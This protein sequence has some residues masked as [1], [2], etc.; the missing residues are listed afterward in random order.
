MLSGIALVIAAFTPRRGLGV[1]AIITVLVVL[2]G[3]GGA[4]QG[5]A[6]ELNSHPAAGWFGLISPF[7]VVQGVQTWLLHQP[8]P[9][10]ADPPGTVG[11]LVFCA[12]T[13]LL[14]AGCY[15]LLLLRYRRVSVS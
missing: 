8:N 13:V 10:P 12:V 3:V 7:S 11:G 15:G 2:I 9:L 1:A 14:V 5:I 6:A 4:A